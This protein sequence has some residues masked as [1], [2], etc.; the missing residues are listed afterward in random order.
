MQVMRRLRWLR[1]W[2]LA[3][4]ACGFGA[5]WAAP[6]CVVSSSK[7]V[8]FQEATD[9][10]TQE[11]GRN[12]VAR[13]EMQSTAATEVQEGNPCLQDA[14]IIV[15]LGTEA[16][17]LIVGRNTRATVF[18]GLIP[19]ISFEQTLADA[20]KRPAAGVSAVYLD[21]P[22]AR[23]MDLLRLALPKSR[24]VGVVWGAE[25]ISQ[26]SLLA[27]AAQQRGLELVAGGVNESGQLIH[28]LHAALQDTDVLLAVA[29]STV[30]NSTTVS[31]I[32]MTSYRAKTP[33]LAFSPAY[34]KAGALLS[35]H[36]TPAQAG[37][38]LAAMVLQY[39][40]NNVLAPN[41]YP[42]DFTVTTNDYVARSL[43]LSLDANALSE[44][45]HK[46]EKRP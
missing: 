26:E 11:L 9:A 6:L 10:L 42:V 8:A 34:V 30:Y 17:R 38:Q 32:L 27:T 14:R 46:L 31:N 1:C 22:F 25:S 24:R 5:I 36:T 4:L 39:V 45:L 12:G 20:G 23:Q 40:L 3:G 18:A 21:Q 35:V 19:R 15:T 37:T 2:C 28:A 33:V 13:Q 44:R 41:Q 7:A 43:G 16:L 29:D